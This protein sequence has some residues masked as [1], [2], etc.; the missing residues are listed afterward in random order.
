MK[1]TDLLG[2]D[3]A[4]DELDR[5]ADYLVTADEKLIADLV[6][7]RRE[8]GLSQSQVAQEMGLADKSGVSKI[9][10]GL[11]DLQLS[12]LRRY[13]MAVGAVV[14][15]EVRNFND[16]D[17]ATRAHQYFGGESVV[18]ATATPVHVVADRDRPHVYA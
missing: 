9:E 6:R 13:A 7:M 10:S 5:H 8:R 17:G 11:R 1:V 14:I 12:T 4:N 3:L 15:H 18:G 2:I 16:Y